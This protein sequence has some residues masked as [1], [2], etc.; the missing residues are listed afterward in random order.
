M[1]SFDD[2]GQYRR[3]PEADQGSDKE[4]H[5]VV[6]RLGSMVDAA[7]RPPRRTSAYQRL[8]PDAGVAA[9][10]R[11]RERCPVI[12]AGRRDAV[13]GDQY[14]MPASFV[15]NR[16]DRSRRV[17][18]VGRLAEIDSLHKELGAGLSR[19]AE[20]QRLT[21]GSLDLLAPRLAAVTA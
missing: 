12:A 21:P 6:V 4:V 10:Q 18:A 17:D 14:R 1:D 7:R 3:P 8:I 5:E 20:R 19:R 15:I 11:R 13:R 16:R 9:R 2:G